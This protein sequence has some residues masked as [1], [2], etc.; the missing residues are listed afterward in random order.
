MGETIL[1]ENAD[2]GFALELARAATARG[3]RVLGL[4]PTSP[5]LFE[6]ATGGKGVAIIADTGRRSGPAELRSRLK[7][8]RVSIG[9]VVLADSAPRKTIARMRAIQPYLS[10]L[11]AAVVVVIVQARGATA[12]GN[13]ERLVAALERLI[14][15][16][17]LVCSRTRL[18]GL[19]KARSPL[20]AEG[21]RRLI[22]WLVSSRTP[23]MPKQAAGR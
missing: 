17:V 20:A 1:L 14:A 9:L 15:A 21:A 7:E 3:D 6:V 22:E 11:P 10:T 19:D 18:A 16:P 4:V 2:R 23:E 12:R 13:R 8:A 5:S